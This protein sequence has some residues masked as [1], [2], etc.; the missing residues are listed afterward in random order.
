MNRGHQILNGHQNTSSHFFS[1]SFSYWRF[2]RKLCYKYISLNIFK[3]NL[4]NLVN[5]QHHIQQRKWSFAPLLQSFLDRRTRILKLGLRLLS[6]LVWFKGALL[7]KIDHARNKV[8]NAESDS[9][10]LSG[11]ELISIYFMF[12]TEQMWR[13]DSR[14]FPVTEH[15]C[16]IIK[17][18]EA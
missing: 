8:I 6:G 10:L 17:D 5:V 15:F 16:R 14:W 11:T 1:S 7:N 18:R 2:Y 4:L 3:N 13:Y 12:F 9:T